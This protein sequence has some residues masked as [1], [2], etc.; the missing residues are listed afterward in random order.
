MLIPH[1]TKL[2][3]LCTLIFTATAFPAPFLNLDAPVAVHCQPSCQLTYSKCFAR[4]GNSDFCRDLVND[5][6]DDKVI[7]EQD[8]Y[9]R[10]HGKD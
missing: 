5:S 1:P 10:W 9:N 3:A 6:Y 7:P 4:S 2:L 8:L